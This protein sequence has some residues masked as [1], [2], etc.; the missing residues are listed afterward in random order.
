MKRFLS[1]EV[2]K[3]KY[4]DYVLSVTEPFEYDKEEGETYIENPTE[5]DKAKFIH[6]RFLSE[7]EWRARQLIRIHGYRHAY[8]MA[9]EEWA[10]GLPSGIHISFWD[11]ECA[12]LGKEWRNYRIADADADDVEVYWKGIGEAIFSI[13][14]EYDSCGK[15]LVYTTEGSTTAPDGEVFENCQILSFEEVCSAEVAIDNAYEDWSSHG[16]SKE[17]MAA[18]ETD[19]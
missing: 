15:Y 19:R 2:S 1:Y 12:K 14:L 13:Y 17:S 16:F 3:V 9:A 8:T 6:N 4:V 18:V 11:E 10:R 7:Y 5:Y